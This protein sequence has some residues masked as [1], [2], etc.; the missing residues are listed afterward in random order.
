MSGIKLLPYSGT[1]LLNQHSHVIF[2]HRL[3]CK[4]RSSS[5]TY[6][7]AS[8]CFNKPSYFLFPQ[9]FA[10]SCIYYHVPSLSFSTITIL[11]AAC[12]KK[13]VCTIC[14]EQKHHAKNLLKRKSVGGLHDAGC[15][16]C[17]CSIWVF[18]K[19]VGFP[20]KS[21][22]F[23]G[24]SIINHPFWG[25]TIFGNTHFLSF[26]NSLVSCVGVLFT[27]DSLSYVNRI[28]PRGI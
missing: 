26:G 1:S 19:I 9:T 12:K 27:K 14:V 4:R 21:S 17:P 2:P 16:S 20:P 13:H 3:H 23:I 8:T 18:P 15:K 25:T 28:P 6:A 11:L 24:F 22:I 7:L 10:C 5:C